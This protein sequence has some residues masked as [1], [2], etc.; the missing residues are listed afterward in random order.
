MAAPVK[1]KAT[2]DTFIAIDF[3]TQTS[4]VIGWR[5]ENSVVVADSATEVEIPA[6]L[7]L[8]ADGGTMAGTEARSWQ[9]LFPRETLLGPKMLLTAD[10][11]ALEARG[12]FFP[13][14]V[15]AGAGKL[16]QLE[17]GGRSRTAVELVALYL[18]Y[19]HRQAEIALE[20]PVSGAVITVPVSFSPFDRQAL[21]VA[22]R[23]AGFQRLRLVDEPIA[24]ALA[25]LAHGVRGR[26]VACAWGARH[27]GAAIVELQDEIVRVVAA[28]GSDRMGGED[29]ELA[30]AQDLLARVRREM[31]GPI[32]NEIH[33]SRILLTQA[34]RLVR[35]IAAAGKAELVLR[36][37]GR[38]KPWRHTVSADDLEVW[39][40]P[41]RETVAGLCDRLLADARMSR[42]DLDALLM[43]G[44]MARLPAAARA[45]ETF[46]ARQPLEG[47]DPLDA[48][49]QG[50]LVRAKFLE[51]E[52]PGPLVLDALPA[53]LGLQGQ[54]GQT[55]AL[56][57]RGE[58]VP[59][60]RTELFTTYLERQTEVAVAIFAHAGLRWE[61][62]ARV[63]ISRLP[64]LK[65]GAGADRGHL[66]ARRGRGPHRRGARDHQ[67]QGPRRGRA[68]G[69]GT[70]QLAGVAPGFRAAAA[71]GR[72]VPRAP[73]R[74]AA[75]AGAPAAGHG[76]QHRAEPS[77]FDDARREAVDH[78]QGARSG[79]DAR[80]PRSGRAAEHDP[81]AGRGRPAAAASRA[82]QAGGSAPAVGAPRCG[83]KHVPRADRVLRGGPQP[84]RGGGAHPARLAHLP[85]GGLGRLGVGAGAPPDAPGPARGRA[86]PDPDP[87]EL[88]LPDRAL[89]PAAIR[90]VARRRSTSRSTTW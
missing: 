86:Q 58:T 15:S 24:A 66:R 16:A 68:A 1:K 59:A 50:A 29:L 40:A 5:G 31:P 9:T 63:E 34:Q 49:A 46:F 78:E 73:V 13:H 35:E 71:R 84:D 17:L 21:R 90:L 44:G 33:V 18:A 26:I 85:R 7:L 11:Q 41:M 53:S 76:A 6:V 56:L 8:A 77:G 3:G 39:L 62:S 60:S 75:G 79:G 14:P 51:H 61:P 43:A 2:E 88:P 32:E 23:L 22:A 67:E 10:P 20:H 38:E 47:I 70:Q 37:P 69:T 36:L 28:V 83:G 65:E 4:R 55:L 64:A 82:R 48:A 52:L 74:G 80:E 87:G 19:L 27:F 42:S 25:A 72:R 57:D 30:L 54:G 81:G 12:A 89:G 45:I